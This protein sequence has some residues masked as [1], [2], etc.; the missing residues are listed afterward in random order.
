M[1]TLLKY[2]G[3]HFAYMRIYYY[4]LIPISRYTQYLTSPKNGI[5]NTLYG[6]LLTQQKQ[7]IRYQKKVIFSMPMTATP[8]AEPINNKLP[9]VPVQ[10]AAVSKAIKI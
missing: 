4:K 2:V 9:P 10:Y 3:I 8:A 7:Y 6:M 5:S 1:K